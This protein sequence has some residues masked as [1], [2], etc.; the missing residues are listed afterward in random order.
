MGALCCEKPGRM[1]LDYIRAF[2][3]MRRAQL[4]G[5]SSG[6]RSSA[7]LEDDEVMYAS[8]QGLFYVFLLQVQ[9]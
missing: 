7:G 1:D 8:A 4:L 3:V 6:P 2:L 9:N 5:S